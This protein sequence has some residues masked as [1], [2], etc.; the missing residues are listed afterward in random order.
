MTV[1]DGYRVA[2]HRSQ[3]AAAES[4]ITHTSGCTWTSGAN[5]A[6]NAN[7]K[8]LDGDAVHAKVARSEEKNPASPGWSLEDLD[9]AMSRL[10]VPFGIGQGG[11]AGVRSARANG[12]Y[13]V[14]QGDSDVFTSGCSGTY[15]GNHAIG[16]H[17][18]T[19]GLRWWIN[20][21]ICPAGRWEDEAILHKYAAKLSASILYGVFET[22]VPRPV[23]R[24]TVHIAH[25][26]I[27]RVYTIAPSGCIESRWTDETWTGRASTAAASRPVNRKTCNRLS[28]ATTTL[29]K[30]GRYKGKHIRV[31]AGVTV[32]EAT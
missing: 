1:L 18:A 13:I 6:N 16:I 25:N 22:K 10:G 30:N 28:S 14:L 31:G 15:D 20:D 4:H 29:V 19:D 23:V 26:A 12:L 21:P 8:A 27:V 7:G 9:L 2:P 24:Y 5:G 3:Y 32:T 17:P 11:W